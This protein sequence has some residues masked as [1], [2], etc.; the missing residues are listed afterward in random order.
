MADLTGYALLFAL[1]LALRR[2][3]LGIGLTALIAW[4]GTV[5]HEAC[6]ALVGLVLGGQPVGFTLWPKRLA[7]GRWQLGSV[8]FRALHWWSAPPTALAPLALAPAA[9]WLL[10]NW[11]WPALAQAQYLAAAGRIALCAILMQAA[12]PSLTDFR[13]AGPGAL[14]FGAIGFAAW[15]WLP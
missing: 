4:P 10:Q 9:V 13:V 3:Q 5:A 12:W 15:W 6:H 11:A 8:S 2:A 7:P 1:V 14:I